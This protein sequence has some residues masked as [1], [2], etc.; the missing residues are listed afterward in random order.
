LAVGLLAGQRIAD[1][2]QA[3]KASRRLVAWTMERFAAAHG[4]VNCRELTGVNL[5]D[6]EQHR[7]FIAGGAWRKTCMKGIEFAVQELAELADEETWQRAIPE[8]LY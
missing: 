3:K 4:T 2:R 1:H 6:E 8:V 7:Q 5:Q